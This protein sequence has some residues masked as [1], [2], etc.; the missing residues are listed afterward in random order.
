[1]ERREE[2]MKWWNGRVLFLLLLTIPL[3]VLCRYVPVDG[4][5]GDALW[6]TRLETHMTGQIYKHMA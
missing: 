5:C 6:Q 1:M 3:Q 2:E 4:E